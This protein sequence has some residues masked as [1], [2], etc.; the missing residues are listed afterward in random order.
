MKYRRFIT[1]LL[2]LLNSRQLVEE[3]QGTD[4]KELV[5]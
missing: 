5:I 2:F 4:R 3:L 1:G